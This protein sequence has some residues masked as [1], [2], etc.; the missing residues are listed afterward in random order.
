MSKLDNIFSVD[1][2]ADCLQLIEQKLDWG[3]SKEWKTQDF[4]QLSQL[5]KQKTGLLLSVTTLKRIWG[6]IKYDSKPNTS[7]LNALAQFVDS[8]DWKTFKQPN[9]IVEPKPIETPIN[10]HHTFS[11]VWI[12]VPLFFCVGFGLYAFS[13]STKSAIDKSKFHFDHRKITDGLP[14]SV[15]FEYDASFANAGD[16]IAIQQNWD[17]QR[18]TMVDRNKKVMTSTYYTPGFFKAKLLVNNQIVK[19]QDVFIPTQGWLCLVEQKP[20]PLYFTKEE[21]ER[22]DKISIPVDLL[23][24]NDINPRLNDTW[25]SFYKVGDFGNQS[26]AN[27]NM[28]FVFFCKLL[29]RCCT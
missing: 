20:V 24:A 23:N 22:K 8:K 3:S 15:V 18:R 27:F 26:V 6:R 13:K 10:K 7:T 17:N 14:N 11:F 28:D 1:K 5:I 16:T 19:E 4:E 12:L 9:Q 29:Q 25:V 21:I 2:L